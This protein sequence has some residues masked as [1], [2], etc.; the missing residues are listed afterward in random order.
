MIP[1]FATQK[2]II[3]TATKWKDK[4]DAFQL[5]HDYVK[6]NV[7]SLS[8]YSEALVLY[9]LNYTNQCNASNINIL[10]SGLDFLKTIC[11]RYSIGPRISSTLVPCFLNKVFL[12][13]TILIVD[14]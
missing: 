4:V 10:R 7:N 1:V 13:F 14:S 2:G 9:S 6:E 3:D 11:E 5:I 12:H 8:S